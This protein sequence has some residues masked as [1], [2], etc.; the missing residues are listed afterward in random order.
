MVQ[1]QYK[2]RAPT[3][4][5]RLPVVMDSETVA[6]VLGLCVVQVRTLAREGKIPAFRVGNQWRFE[7]RKLMAFAGAIE[8]EVNNADD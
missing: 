8:S 5:E 3:V 2:K 4:W 1:T 6:V 7:K